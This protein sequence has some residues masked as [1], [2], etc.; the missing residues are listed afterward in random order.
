MEKSFRRA[1]RH[2]RSGH[3]RRFCGR[4]GPRPR[5]Q[6]RSK[7]FNQ[8]LL[9]GSNAFSEPLDDQ[10]KKQCGQLGGTLPG[11]QSDHSSL[12]H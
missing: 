9:G 10:R 8:A 3:S 1:Y 11:H 6:L 2:H 12:S 7:S 4:I 5:Q